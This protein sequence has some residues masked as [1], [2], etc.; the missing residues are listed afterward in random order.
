MILIYYAYSSIVRMC[1]VK[2][3]NFRSVLIIQVYCRN[4]QFHSSIFDRSIITV[5]FNQKHCFTVDDGSDSHQMIRLKDSKYFESIYYSF[6]LQ[7]AQFFSAYY[8]FN[9]VS[10]FYLQNHLLR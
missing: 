9:L 3:M 7:T 8:Q 2:S 5:W 10:L 6:R 1:K 4:V